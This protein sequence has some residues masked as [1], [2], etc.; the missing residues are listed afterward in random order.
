MKEIDQ[1]AWEARP[2]RRQNVALLRAAAAGRAFEERCRS[3][4]TARRK[5]VALGVAR[6]RLKAQGEPLD[7]VIQRDGCVVRVGPAAAPK[8]GVAK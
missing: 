1:T 7:V 5:A 3:C 4:K 8:K 6:G 2:A